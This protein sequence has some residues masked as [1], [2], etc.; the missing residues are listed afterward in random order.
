MNIMRY[1]ESLILTKQIQA[2]NP[3]STLCLTFDAVWDD[4]QY[5]R[6]DTF[7]PPLVLPDGY[8]IVR[9]GNDDFVIN[10]NNEGCYIGLARYKG[11]FTVVTASSAP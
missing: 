7:V 5:I 9:E 1:E 4:E 2:L 8:H 3:Q 10:A 11:D 6:F